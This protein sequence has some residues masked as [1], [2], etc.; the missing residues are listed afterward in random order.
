M[1]FEIEGHRGARG[2]VP[3][4][5]IPSFKKAI[6]LGAHV[7]ELDV[8]ISKDKQVVV[9]HD[10][11]FNPEITTDPKGEF[12]TKETQG[13]LY[14][15]DYKEI[16]KYDVGLRG[17]KGFPEQEKMKVYKPLLKDMIREIEKYTKQ[18]GLPAVKYNV[19]IKSNEKE[20]GKSQPD[21]A[22]FSDLV[23]KILVK[24]LPLER[25]NMQSFDYNMLKYWH[26]QMQ[27]GKYKKVAMA[28]LI[29]PRANNDVQVNIDKLGFKPDIWSPYF[30][31]VN[32]ER[33]KQLHDLGIRVIPWTVNKREEMEKVKAVGCDG[34]ITDYPDRAKGL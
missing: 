16:K 3:E 10:T 21:Y 24:E 4:N 19:E 11:Y 31:Q 12:V 29:E 17:N 27:A 13:N 7:L 22:E 26:A 1:T 32:A 8:V 20:I 5:T 18:K 25:V 15:L 33:V 14:T 30:T 34:V 9:S 23:Y 6:D 28:V 2:L